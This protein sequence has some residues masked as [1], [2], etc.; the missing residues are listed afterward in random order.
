ML[1]EKSPIKHL[2][3]E[4]PK[5][6]YVVTHWRGEQSLAR[7]YWING[8]LFSALINISI[9]IAEKPLSKLGP[10][11]IFNI[12]LLYVVC[13]AIITGWQLVGVW[14]S[15]TNHSIKTMRWFWASAAKVIVVIVVLGATANLSTM[16]KD[17]FS[18]LKA[19]ND[20][21]LADY[22]IERIGDTN[23]IFTGAINSESVS[24]LVVALED[25]AIT[26]L[27][28]NSHGGLLEPAIT[29]AR[30]IRGREF[31]VMAEIQCISACVILLAGS[32]NAAIYPGSKVSFHRFEAI[33]EFS[34]PE[35]RRETANKLREAEAIYREFGISEWAIK[36]ARRQEYWTPTLNQMIQ[37]NLIKYVFSISQNQF[38]TAEEYCTSHLS[39]CDQFV[40]KSAVESYQEGKQQ[41]VLE[42]AQEMAAQEIRKQAPIQIDEITTLQSAH[43]V[44]K[45]LIYNHRLSLRKS[46]INDNFVAEMRK[47]LKHNVCQNKGMRITLNIGGEFT[48][49]YLSLDGLLIGEIKITSSDCS[50]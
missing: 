25:P 26:I 17:A 44:G 49:I 30:L 11:V 6:E 4:L 24:E 13:L 43:S 42:K 16:G 8:L 40:G 21:R 23:L 1:S 34:N 41:G 33:A 50:L 5:M 10:E 20:P 36:T 18:G 48:Y 3:E 31:T 2:P 46:D 14:R 9:A 27:R 12:L 47:S 7:S 38:V 39:E 19:L 22:T 35:I 15:A 45:T 32:P 37:M 29:L 28:I